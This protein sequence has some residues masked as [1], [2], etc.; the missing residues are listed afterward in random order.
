MTHDVLERVWRERNRQFQKLSETNLW[1]CA[2]P[3][4]P[5]TNQLLVLVEEVGEVARCILDAGFNA[6]THEQFKRELEKE[7][8]QTAAV[9]VACVES[10]RR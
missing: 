10:L 9:A 4:T 8:I 5:H 6:V 2:D 1:D 7:L 3:S